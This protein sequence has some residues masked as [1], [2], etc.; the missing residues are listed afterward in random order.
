VGCEVIQKVLKK[1]NKEM[2]EHLQNETSPIYG[3]KP[4]STTFTKELRETYL[5]EREK[6]LS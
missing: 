4:F 6:E 3:K 2:L 5:K 1:N